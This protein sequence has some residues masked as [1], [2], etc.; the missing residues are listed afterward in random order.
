MCVVFVVLGLV[1]LLSKVKLTLPRP[2]VIDVV[3]SGLVGFGLFLF[4]TR[5]YA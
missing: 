5:G 1:F 3:S 2:L 4:V